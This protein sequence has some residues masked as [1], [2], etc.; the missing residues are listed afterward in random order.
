MLDAR[1]VFLPDRWPV[2][3]HLDDWPL[4]GSGTASSGSGKAAAWDQ[5]RPDSPQRGPT[6]QQPR[7]RRVLVQAVIR[8]V[9]VEETPLGVEYPGSPPLG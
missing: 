8:C 5:R 6:P 7:R 2:I 9:P 3:L 4:V 1:T